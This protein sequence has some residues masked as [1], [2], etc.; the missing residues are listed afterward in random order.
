M[1][2]FGNETQ[3]T[4]EPHTHAG[5]Q[6]L[7]LPFIPPGMDFLPPSV[8]AQAAAST[9]P[10]DA[11]FATSGTTNQACPGSPRWQFT[12]VPMAPAIRSFNLAN[13]VAMAC[14]EARRQQSW[15]ESLDEACQPF[16]N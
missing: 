10:D 12:Y 6:V 9:P 3:G 11:S 1:L 14:Y 15:P 7:T 8:L 16:N 13:T 2:V 5:S 4:I